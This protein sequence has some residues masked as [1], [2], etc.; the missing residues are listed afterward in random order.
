MS[1]ISAKR[2]SQDRRN[3][4][5]YK[6]TLKPTLKKPATK[7]ITSSR[8][9]RICKLTENVIACCYNLFS[10]KYTRNSKF[11][12]AIETSIEEDEA[13]YSSNVLHSLANMQLKDTKQPET[14]MQFAAKCPV[15]DSMHVRLD[16][17]ENFSVCDDCGSCFN[18]QGT[19]SDWGGIEDP[20]LMLTCKY[21]TIGKSFLYEV[22][23]VMRL[24]DECIEDAIRIYMRTPKGAKWHHWCAASLLM[25][26]ASEEPMEEDD[27][28]SVPAGWNA[29]DCEYD[30]SSRQ[31]KKVKFYCANR[32]CPVLKERKFFHTQEEAR[33]HA[34]CFMGVYNTEFVCPHTKSTLLSQWKSTLVSHCDE[35][36]EGHK[37]D[38]YDSLP[39]R[40]TT[41]ETVVGME[42]RME[43]FSVHYASASLFHQA[44]DDLSHLRRRGK[45]NWYRQFD[46]RKPFQE[47]P[48]PDR[49][50]DEKTGMVT[51]YTREAMYQKHPKYTLA[52]YHA[53]E[54]GPDL[55]AAFDTERLAQREEFLEW[56]EAR[57]KER[58][59]HEEGVRRREAIGEARRRESIKESEGYD[60]DSGEKPKTK[61]R[62]SKQKQPSKREK[63]FKKGR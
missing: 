20:H 49:R 24:A 30:P 46:P 6:P 19:Y 48:D 63:L 9:V 13:A 29:E 58:I 32:N 62:K 28:P 5:Q 11:L 52:R 35:M 27:R 23:A 39:R 50:L 38:F 7:Y 45:T 54:R 44:F 51:W 16:M 41:Y 61:K 33:H 25:S 34:P 21:S 55:P 14:C 17:R 2:S 1:S 22:G 57:R 43:E 10:D 4:H 36:H 56:Q 8:P 12:G 18:L 60:A 3:A 40:F 15:C 59:K 26:L 31:W 53:T 37:R 47:R 42:G